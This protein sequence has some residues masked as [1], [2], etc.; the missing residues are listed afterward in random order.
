[1]AL[2]KIEIGVE[3]LQKLLPKLAATEGYECREK[4]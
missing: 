2:R 3:N 1:M 4:F